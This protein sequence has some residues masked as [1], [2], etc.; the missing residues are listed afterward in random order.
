MIGR[1]NSSAEQ[2]WWGGSAHSNSQDTSPTGL[3]THEAGNRS[4]LG[5]GPLSLGWDP[6]SEHQLLLDHMEGGRRLSGDKSTA[7][8]KTGSLATNSSGNI[9]VS[10]KFRQASA[11]YEGG[12]FLGL[13]SMGLPSQRGPFAQCA[14]LSPKSSLMHKGRG[15]LFVGHASHYSRP[16]LFLKI[17]KNRATV[18]IQTFAAKGSLPLHLLGQELFHLF[19]PVFSF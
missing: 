15:H 7:G 8:G 13:F 6:L 2:G 4:A 9:P 5:G 14:T 1:E 3:Q 17:S 11:L 12:I 18:L 10:P 16:V 19:S